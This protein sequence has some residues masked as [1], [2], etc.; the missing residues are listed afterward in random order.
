M[1]EAWEAI[2]DFLALHYRFN[3]RLDTPFW[4]RC[5]EETDIGALGPFLDFY[6]ENGPSG[7]GQR[8]LPR[9]SELFHMEGYLALLIG[10]RVPYR[11]ARSPCRR[12]SRV[13]GGNFAGEM[14]RSY[15]RSGRPSRRIL[16]STLLPGPQ[17]LRD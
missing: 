13:F 16:I 15:H 5:R 17:S 9:G 2:R 4:R 14:G 8:L 7:F 1:A 12:L 6:R 11:G 10:M 3:T